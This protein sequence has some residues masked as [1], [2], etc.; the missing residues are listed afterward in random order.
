[1]R[2][3]VLLEAVVIA[4]CIH[5]ASAWAEGSGV[6]IQIAELFPPPGGSFIPPFAGNNSFQKFDVEPVH[7]SLLLK[8]AD[9]SFKVKASYAGKQAGKEGSN[10]ILGKA[11]WGGLLNFLATSSFFGGRLGGEGEV[12]YSLVD[13][14]KAK[15]LGRG[16][17]S[18]LRFGLKGAWGGF[19][20]GAEYRSVEKDF[21]DSTGSKVASDQKGGQVWGQRSF[22]PVRVKSSVSQFWNDVDG[23]PQLPRVTNST[24][25]TFHYSRSTW[26]TTLS[27]TYSLVSERFG[28]RK[29]SVVFSHVLRGSYRPTGAITIIPTFSLRQENNHFSRIRTE[30][31]SASL[32]LAYRLLHDVLT[33]T[34]L[35]SYTGTWSSDRLKDTRTLKLTANMDW[36]LGKSTPGTK[37]LSFKFSYKHHLDITS[38]D[39]SHDHLSVKLLL[40]IASF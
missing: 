28:P 9:E 37:T 39:S 27:S 31:P 10:G 6:Q 34:A 38:P 1:M 32:S 26:R 12:A 19:G 11:E 3:S 15:G 30:T 29:K 20:Y 21:V 35:G 14:E 33:F 5:G 36:N 23:N 4:F 22:G 7:T 16:W 8:L 24:T 18:L 17:P 40:K 13:A 2:T 25:T